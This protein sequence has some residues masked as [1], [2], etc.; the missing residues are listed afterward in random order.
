MM[1]NDYLEAL[2]SAHSDVEAQ[3]SQGN[4]PAWKTSLS[5]FKC[6]IPDA[7]IY[8]PA[9]LDLALENIV[10]N[11]PSSKY[12]FSI[13]LTACVKKIVDP[14]QDI[15]IA[16]TSMANG[17]S[18]RS[19]DQTV[20]T[21]FLKR[22]NYTHCEASGLESGRNLERP[23]PWDLSYACNPR[24]KGNRESFLTTLN[25]IE[26]E[27]GSP[28]IVLRYLLFL[29]AQNRKQSATL[30]QAPLE[31]NIEKIMNIFNRHFAE[32]SGQ[33]K[34]RLPVL[35]LYSLYESLVDEVGRYEGTILARLERH[36]TADLR[37]GSIGDIQVDKDDL[38]FEGVEVKSEKPITV[39]MIYELPRKFGVRKISRYYLLTTYPGS[40]RPEDKVAVENAVQKVQLETGCQV[41]VNGLN[42]SIWYYLRLIKDPSEIL[43]RYVELLSVDPDVRPELIEKWN[44]L[45]SEQYQT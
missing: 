45:V 38:P 26:V 40:V 4:T 24:G 43:A 6:Q 1:T 16:Q 14:K 25:F 5:R 3:L 29:D 35:A 42:S 9:T 20:V 39:D 23:H 13:V 21:P 10:K 44:E 19:L 8:T 31:T 30:T 41:I 36:T 33:G 18:N 2:N 15:R 37:S 7:S 12:I 34:S 11:I 17:Y 28:E 27:K 22:F 32:S